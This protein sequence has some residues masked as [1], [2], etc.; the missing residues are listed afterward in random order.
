MATNVSTNSRRQKVCIQISRSI[1]FVYS[2]KRFYNKHNPHRYNIRIIDNVNTHKNKR[3]NSLG[4][5][6]RNYYRR[7]D[8]DA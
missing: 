1:S 4:R 6:A 3:I 2:P 8:D 5:V 7:N